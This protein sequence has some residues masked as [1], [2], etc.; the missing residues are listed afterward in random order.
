MTPEDSC[1]ILTCPI[2]LLFE[3]YICCKT[4]YK[5]QQERPMHYK[6]LPQAVTIF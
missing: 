4:T 5:H 1:Y 6:P 3:I 2:K